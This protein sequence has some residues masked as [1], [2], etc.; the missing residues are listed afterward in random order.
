LLGLFFIINIKLEIPTKCKRLKSK[1][2]LA[3]E[4]VA[5]CRASKRKALENLRNNNHPHQ[6]IFQGSRV[7]CRQRGPGTVPKDN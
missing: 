4:M 1:R 5:Q 7:L 6:M 2:S 3:N